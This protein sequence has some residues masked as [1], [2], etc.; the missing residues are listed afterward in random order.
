MPP[1]SETAHAATP[2]QVAAASDA[3]AAAESG[4]SSKQPAPQQ[5]SRP[6]VQSAVQE[7]STAGS[8]SEA[9]EGGGVLGANPSLLRRMLGADD[10]AE[11]LDILVQHG[12]ADA[13]SRR[14][15]TK[16]DA[17]LL[18]CS[19]LQQG[20]TSLAL[21]LYAD[22]CRAR[23]AVHAR[24]ASPGADFDAAGLPS[25]P[26]ATLQLTS[27]LVLGLCRQLAVSQALDVIDGIK[28][29][30]MPR[31]EE[32]SFGFV[33]SSP[34]LPTQPLAVVQPQEGSR[35]VA[36]SISRYE[37]ELFS[38]TVTSC[39]SEA[40]QPA[41]GGL[42]GAAVRAVGLLRKPLVAAVH[43][44]VVRAP[45]GLSRTFRAG[46]AS[47]DVPAQVGV[48]A[49]GQQGRAAGWAGCAGD[50]Q[51]RLLR[52]PSAQPRILPWARAAPC[53]TTR[54][55]HRPGRRGWWRACL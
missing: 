10:A 49:Q 22:M 25:W 42:L 55:W 19:S 7:P 11:A 48:A 40:L 15:L 52:R 37:F 18:M 6:P 50:T 5:Q 27:E 23:R 36:D 38:G 20:N 3:A 14:R 33:V 35:V 24:S 21:S 51:A 16:A 2:A 9:D 46:T 47:A 44:L 26:P 30:G 34:L 13:R 41:D 1:P 43:E 17:T 54:P 12:G 4:G 45:D 32:V 28:A 31:A 8:S 53:D 39:K 29:Q